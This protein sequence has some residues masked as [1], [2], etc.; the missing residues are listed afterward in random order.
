MK[1]GMSNIS[2]RKLK[3]LSTI[4]A[5]SFLL[6]G[7]AFYN[8][9]PLVYPD[10]VGYIGLK[11]NG[12]RSIFYNLF[13]YPSSWFHS[14]WPVVFLQSLIV[15]HLL[16]L[17]L[18]VVFRVTSHI[19]YLFIIAAYVFA[20]KPAMVYGFHYAGYLYRDNDPF[21]LPFTILSGKPRIMGKKISFPPDSH[22]CHGSLDAYS[23]CL[24]YDCNRLVFPG[25]N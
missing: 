19:A 4:I 16:Y 7:I 17:V 9:Y 13:I 1:F 20:H 15:A 8:G 25:N 10:T 2:W 21:A 14:L 6:S 23:S 22:I 3:V 12:I 5:A 11:A 24:G 18:R